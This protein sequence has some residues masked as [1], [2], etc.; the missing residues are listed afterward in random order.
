MITQNIASCFPSCTGREGKLDAIFCVIMPCTSHEGKLNTIFCVILHNFWVIVQSL[1]TCTQGTDLITQSFW[2]ICQIPHGLYM[3]ENLTQLS[4]LSGKIVV[5]CVQVP[6]GL[7]M[8]DMIT[9]PPTLVRSLLPPSLYWRYRLGY[10]ME[11]VVWKSYTDK[12][13][14]WTNHLCNYFLTFT[15]INFEYW[16]VLTWYV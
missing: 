12:K 5:L 11:M 7:Y 1:T 16:Y 6:H 8:R 2:V 13:V 15:C 14:L 4:A 3:R 9:Q 10:Q